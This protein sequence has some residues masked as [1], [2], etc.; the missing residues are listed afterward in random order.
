MTLS[1]GDDFHQFSWTGG[2]NKI[3]CFAQMDH[4]F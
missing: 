3:I 2:S 4:N 1:K